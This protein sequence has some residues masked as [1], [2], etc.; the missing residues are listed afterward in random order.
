MEISRGL[1]QGGG[2]HYCKS[3]KWFFLWLM[4]NKTLFCARVSS[5]EAASH[6]YIKEMVG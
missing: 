5:V 2:I 6:R 1:K 3:N 4:T